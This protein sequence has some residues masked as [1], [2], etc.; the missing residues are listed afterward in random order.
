MAIWGNVPAYFGGIALILTLLI[1]LRDRNEKIR[2]QADRLAAWVERAK[3]DG[4]S[5]KV[6]I[7][8]A[9]DLPCMNIGYWIT[10]GYTQ[11][12]KLRFSKSFGANTDRRRKPDRHTCRWAR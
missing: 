7:R 8:N 2:H 12:S 11:P 9:S 6:L 1:I 5:H 4:G 10:E 3:E